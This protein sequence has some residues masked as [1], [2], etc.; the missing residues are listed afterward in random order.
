MIGWVGRGYVD[1]RDKDELAAQSRR[2]RR[3]RPWMWG[4]LGTMWAL[5]YID[6]GAAMVFGPD[7]Y[8]WKGTG[9]DHETGRS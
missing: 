6:A 8:K 7:T 5:E 3:W 1:A 9:E 2:F 4:P